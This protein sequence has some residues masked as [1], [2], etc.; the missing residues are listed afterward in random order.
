MATIP[1]PR[2]FITALVNSLFEAQSTQPTNPK[3][4][5]FLTLHAL[6][7]STLLPALDLLDRGLV[8]KLQI[9]P[10]ICMYLVRSAPPSSSYR[11]SRQRATE[12][13]EFVVTTMGWN[14]ECPT[15]AYAAYGETGNTQS[16]KDGQLDLAGAP[17]DW[18]G[19]G[20]SPNVP[21]CKHLL[22]C[23]LAEA[24]PE[25]LGKSVVVKE[26]SREEAAGWAAG[27]GST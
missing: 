7:P 27:W 15:F 21:V 17:G 12:S 16:G 13:K 11:S 22:A 1:S 3:S 25:Q 24:W 6:L 19:L 26:C 9:S 10:S 5:Q 2:E 23:Y 8:R 18:G 14:C 4:S 20:I